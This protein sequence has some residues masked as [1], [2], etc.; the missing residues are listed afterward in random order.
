MLPLPGLRAQ[1]D[2]Y[3]GDS[4]Y[5]L[6]PTHNGQTDGVVCA[7]TSSEIFLRCGRF[8]PIVARQL[9]DSYLAPQWSAF[10][11]RMSTAVRSA[12]GVNVSRKP[13]AQGRSARHGVSLVVRPT[14]GLSL[15][16]ASLNW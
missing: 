1:L 7:F 6:A 5:G 14:Q 12:R 8:A 9:D 13:V 4:N 2:G 3:A 15:I 11:E 16:T 10:V